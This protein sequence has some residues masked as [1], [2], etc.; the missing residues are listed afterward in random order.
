MLRTAASGHVS[1]GGS[2]FS[3]VLPTDSAMRRASDIGI[4]ILFSRA[5]SASISLDGAGGGGGG[6]APSS[7]NTGSLRPA[8]TIV[9][10][11][12]PIVG[13]VGVVG[14]G[15]GAIPGT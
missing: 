14:V 11:P 12:S 3:G 9:S 6:G 13:S 7:L 1:T 4:P 5:A 15:G 8:G 10:Q 2:A